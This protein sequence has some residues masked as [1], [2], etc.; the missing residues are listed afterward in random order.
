MISLKHLAFA[1][2]LIAANGCRSNPADNAADKAAGSRVDKMTETHKVV[3][4]ENDLATASANFEAQREVRVQALQ[5]ELG[6]T[7]LQPMMI[8]AIA[9][10]FPLTA[11]SRADV[12]DK[13]QKLQMRLDEAT[14]QV[15]ALEH[16][17]SDTFKDADDATRETFDKLHDARKDAWDA[18]KD[19]HR[20]DRSS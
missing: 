11:D 5:A 20:T 1:V 16:A 9:D 17:S 19:A 15:K 10:N 3:E 18:V 6:V 14:N 2:G 8:N 4:K 7:K 13:L 12:T